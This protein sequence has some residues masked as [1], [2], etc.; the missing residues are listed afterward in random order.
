MHFMT[1]TECRI[2]PGRMQDFVALVQHWEQ[3]ARE[4]EFAPEFHGVYLQEADPSRVLVITQFASRE[5]AEAFSRTGLA[6]TFR[7]QV[8]TCSETPP[9]EVEGFDLFYATLADGSR[10]VFG[11]DG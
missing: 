2:A 4:S 3:E 5:S 9:G 6:E 11:E 1:V 7:E 10:V 8:M